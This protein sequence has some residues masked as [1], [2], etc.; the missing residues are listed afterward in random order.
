VDVTIARSSVLLALVLSLCVLDARAAAGDAAPAQA[1]P[2][3]GIQAKNEG[4][5]VRVTLAPQTGWECH[6][7]EGAGDVV[8]DL[9]IAP[10]GLRD[11]YEGLPP[12]VKE[13]VAT[14]VPGGGGTSLRIVVGVGRLTEVGRDGEA[15]RLRF[16]ARPASGGAV[17]GS[18]GEYRVGPGDKLDITVFGHDDLTKL[19]EVRADGTIKFP[20]IGDIPVAGKS[21]GEIDDD[22]TRALG[23]DYLVDPQVTVDVHEYQSQSVTLLGEVTRPGRY[24]LKRNMRLVDLLADAG[25]PSK[26]AGSEILIRR[27]SADGPGD[28]IQVPLESLYQRDSEEANVLLRGGDVVTIAERQFF[29]VKGEVMRPNGY[30]LETGMTLLRAVSLAGGLSQFANRHEVEIL[31]ADATGKQGRIVISLKEIESGKRPDPRLK[32][33]DIINVPRRIF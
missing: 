13:I 20:L 4:V 6:V 16:A 17:S 8:L 7:A 23:K 19:V 14:P 12:V 24:V 22:L 29:Y 2:P 31:R 10:A 30:Y 26:E 32:A 11:R 27:A 5:E 28:M 18:D 33:N 1:A 3:V 25:G 15:L 21:A 9:A